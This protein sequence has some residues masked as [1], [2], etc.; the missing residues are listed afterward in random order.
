MLANCNPLTKC[1]LAS[2]MESVHRREK[3]RGDLPGLL[4]I[5][6][7]KLLKSKLEVL[8][9]CLIQSLLVSWLRKAMW[10]LQ[11][12]EYRSNIWS[13]DVLNQGLNW[14]AVVQNKCTGVAVEDRTAN[15]CFPFAWHLSPS[16][17]PTLPLFI[18]N[19]LLPL[20]RTGLLPS[21][22]LCAC[23]NVNRAKTAQ[24]GRRASQRRSVASVWGG[25][26]GEGGKNH[27]PLSKSGTLA[28][29][30]NW[31]ADWE[32]QDTTLASS[33]QSRLHFKPSPPVKS[34]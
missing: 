15:R 26:D 10:M 13:L 25:I 16:P 9:F 30:N 14:R 7:Y 3:Q 29:N 2:G 17:M 23:T 33:F 32:P 28:Y 12:F 31:N 27:P 18:A 22:Q 11:M 21:D 20:I 6:L 8:K 4:I 19:H 1:L 34:L 5:R 24:V